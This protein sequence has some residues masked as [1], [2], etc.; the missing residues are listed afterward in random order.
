MRWQ[1]RYRDKLITNEQAAKLV[2]TGCKVVLPLTG[3]PMGFA[4]AL[5]ARRGELE[6]EAKRTGKKV[7][8]LS[9]WTDDLPFLHKGWEHIF[10]V[11]EGFILRHTRE[12]IRGR[13]IDWV[14]SIF[15]LSDGERQ[16]NLDR[17]NIYSN[18]DFYAV[19]ITPP[20]AHGFSSFGYY[21]WYSPVAARTARTVI[22]EV[23]PGLTWCFG[24]YINIDEIG[25]LIETPPQ[26]PFFFGA[27]PVPPA[28]EFEKAQ[29]IGANV[30]SLIK[31]GDVIEIG[32]GTATEAVFSFLDDKNDLAIDSELIYPP[33]IELMKKGVITNKRKNVNTGKTICTCLFIYPG[34]PKGREALEFVT[35][36]P[37]FDF[38]E[39]SWICNVPRIAAND[40]QV[41]INSAVAIDLKGQ[42]V[43]DHLGPIP[44]SGPG[45]QVEYCIGSHYSRGGKS[46]LCLLSTAKGDTVSRIV[47]QH[48]KGTGIH[49]PLT[50]VDYLVTEHGIANLDGK[51]V[52]ERA[53]ALIS[54]ADPK[55]R[56]ELRE[57]AQ[58][59][60]WP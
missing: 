50:Y 56:D 19:K 38:R 2:T 21:P 1:D 37:L 57:A 24:E 31:D 48:E 47:P 26:E 27:L 60:F 29:V 59:L 32:T 40:N 42:P 54:V 36:N 58:K 34:D 22:A 28:D 30:A 39:V 3:K 7:T 55:F 11:K 15:G 9:H 41:A 23:D 52:R 25:W 49:I 4:N 8:I 18:C 44:I 53:E 33:V 12:G 17:G 14:P 43:I 6:A 13:W 20:N 46:I 51:S 10:D 5:A 16:K 35:E 45:G